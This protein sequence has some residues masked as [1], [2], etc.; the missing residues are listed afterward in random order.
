MKCIN[1]HPIETV[2]RELIH[3]QWTRDYIFAAIWAGIEGIVY[4]NNPQ[5]RGKEENW[6][7]ITCEEVLKA[8]CYI[9]NIKLIKD[10]LI[11]E[12]KDYLIK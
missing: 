12:I 2:M 10:Y 6:S 7:F 1:V 4:A 3:D 8:G 9:N 11:D 5:Y